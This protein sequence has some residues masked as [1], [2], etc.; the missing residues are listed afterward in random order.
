MKTCDTLNVLMGKK[1]DHVEGLFE[2][3]QLFFFDLK[4][5]NFL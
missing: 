1:L 4:N 5:C 2:E 3:S